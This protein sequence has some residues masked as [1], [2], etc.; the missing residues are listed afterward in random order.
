VTVQCRCAITKSKY[1]A[2][3]NEC[4]NIAILVIVK[5]ITVIVKI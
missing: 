1:T 4:R 3:T 2:D 5:I